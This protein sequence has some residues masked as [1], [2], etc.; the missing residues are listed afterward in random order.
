MRL[1]ESWSD[2]CGRRGTRGQGK[3]REGEGDTWKWRMVQSN[4]SN[5]S[6]KHPRAFNQSIVPDGRYEKAHTGSKI[7]AN[8]AT[9]D[10]RLRPATKG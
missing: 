8:V 10:Y 5:R 3:R 4:Y 1:R 2:S 6:G 9:R 7:I